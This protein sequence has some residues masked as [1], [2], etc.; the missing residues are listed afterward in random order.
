MSQTIV[1]TGPLVAYLQANEAHSAWTGAE[2]DRIEPPLLTCE[3]V[4]SEACFLIGRAGGDPDDLL[5]LVE[6]GLIQVAFEL[7][8]EMPRVRALMKRYRKLPM[9]LADGCL[10]RMTEQIVACRLVTFDGHFRIYRRHDRRPIPLL[11]PEEC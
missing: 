10:V 6:R 8:E 11:M 9:S 1:D 2:F 5:E 7:R 3:P 4:L